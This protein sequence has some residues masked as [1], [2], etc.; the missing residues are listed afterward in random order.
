MLAR[1]TGRGDL[2]NEVSRHEAVA[3]ALVNPYEPAVGSLATSFPEDDS[4]LLADRF[5]PALYQ[6]YDLRFVYAAPS[7]VRTTRR[8][9]WDPDSPA[10]KSTADDD[11][12]PR[13]AAAK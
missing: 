8:I 13:V 9:E 12:I 1:L 7:L 2:R 3:L 11:Y 5:F 10:L 6:Q 4:V